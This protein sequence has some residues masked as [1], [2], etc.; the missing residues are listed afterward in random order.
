MKVSLVICS[1]NRM[2]T[3]PKTLEA[4]SFLRYPDLEVIVVDGPS[5]DGT[6]EYV[7]REW[8][9]RVRLLKCPVAN[10]S[11]SRNIG[12]AGAAGDIVAFTDDDGM[13]EPDWIDRLVEAYDDPR[14][15]A[16][17]GWVRDHTG[18][19]YQTRYIVSRRDSTSEVLLES[20]S[21]VPAAVA[22]AVRF[23]GLIGVNSSF[24]RSVLLEIGGFDE[25]YAYFLDE[26]DVLVRLVDAG[27]QVRMLPD[28]QV[29]H[30][31]AASHIRSE[32]GLPKTW[33]QIAK[34]TAY[35]CI[36]NAQPGEPLSS[37]LAL[38]EQHRQR[39]A[40]DT[41][42][43]ASQD[44]W[45]D[46][47]TGEML[48]TLEAGIADGIKAAFSA[49][50]RQLLQPPAEHSDD[51]QVM[52]RTLPAGERRRIALVTELYPPLPCGGVAV[53]MHQLAERLARL[54]HEI[55][56][57]TFGEEG[58]GHTVDF[59]NGVWVHRI[60]RT[61]GGTLRTEIPHMP[62][63]AKLSAQAVLD[64]LERVDGHRNIEW[65]LGAIWD[66]PV[67][68]VLA[69][70]RF[71]VALYLVTS[72]G[73]MLDSKPEWKQ[74]RQYYQEHVLAMIEAEKWAL[75]KADLLLSSTRAIRQ[76][77]EQAYAVDLNGTAI[78]PFGLREG[79][80]PPAEAKSGD[81]VELLFVGRFEP[82]K[83]IDLL[84]ESLPGLMVQRPW[85]KVT[86]A[87]DHSLGGDAGYW[88]EFVERYSG[89]E[90]LSRICV[91]GVLS[92]EELDACYSRCDLFVAPSRYESFGLI[93]LE[94]MRYAKACVGFAVGGVPEVVE[95]GVTGVLSAEVSAAGLTEA[96]ARL[97]DDAELR[98][99]MGRAGRERFEL[100]FTLDRFASGFIKQL[101]LA[102]MTDAVS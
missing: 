39:I 20:P 3:L 79:L 15:G 14:V 10:L 92:D 73:L 93:Y 70:S 76:D 100:L 57:I 32:K 8:D 1:Y 60:P 41:H 94:A 83:G 51:W 96:L 67:A 22:G 43:A 36:R 2:H 91:T 81:S 86:L 40:A 47:A 78:L 7:R 53:F 33:Y 28:A 98:D 45:S 90:W 63:S 69:E 68:A 38:I 52:P 18:V 35:F 4:V 62:L 49:P 11:V 89:A 9:D 88:P 66:L 54:G 85:L 17:G 95:D 82:R 50:W 77:C 55:T 64:E 80:A 23:P 29:H 75:Q 71:R 12:I 48:E 25:L 21:D 19:S 30:K 27:Y 26:T 6:E 59:E 99:S 16:V 74:D 44:D 42:W 34:S 58:R 84:L 13:P 101:E 61:V 56:V 87:G 97:L 24:R 72:Y 37:T 102:E 65:V 46:Q 31:Y 5:T